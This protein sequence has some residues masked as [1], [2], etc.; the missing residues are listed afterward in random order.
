MK[1]LA[2]VV[3]VVLAMLPTVVAGAYAAPEA[4]SA[5]GVGPYEGTFRGVAYGDKGSRAPL[6]LELTHRGSQVKGNL[7]LGEGLHV[8]AGFCGSVNLPAAAQRIES[9]TSFWNPKRLV[10]DPTFD[11]GS[12][13]LTIDFESNVSAEGEVITGSSF[14][15]LRLIV[16]VAES[17][18]EGVPSSVTCTIKVKLGVV[19]KS[20]W[21][22]SATVISP[23]VL[24]M[25]NG[26]APVPPVMVKVSVSTASGSLATTFPTVVP[27]PLFS[28]MK[29]V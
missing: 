23:V 20:N 19:S 10:A 22:T 5:S 25:P 17:D 15:S 9:Q 4:T 24:S 1:R 14:A 18:K 16:I 7:Y 26:V 27:F 2:A 28:A 6:S 12:F 29:K 11:A 13:D 21:V 3:V 8:S